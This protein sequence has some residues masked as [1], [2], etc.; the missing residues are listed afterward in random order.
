MLKNKLFKLFAFF[1]IIFAFCSVSARAS[2][3]SFVRVVGVN[4]GSYD[5]LS[6]T[7]LFST[8]SIT[9]ECTSVTG[10]ITIYLNAGTHSGGSFNPRDMLGPSSSLLAYNLFLDSTYQT[11][12]GDGTG[13]TQYYGPVTPTAGQR[14][15][16]TIYGKVPPLQ[17]V[18]LGFYSD[19]ITAT[20]NFQMCNQ[21]IQAIN[22]QILRSSLSEF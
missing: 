6:S 21:P 22:L 5:Q 18:P 17:N 1:A 16:I 2:S 8:G 14:Y 12:W 10:P 4:F 19:T 15:M 11:I 7:P 3:C 20:L 13:G 9:Y